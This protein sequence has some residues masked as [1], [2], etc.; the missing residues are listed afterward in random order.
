MTH[1]IEITRNVKLGDPKMNEENEIVEAPQAEVEIE[2]PELSPE[3]LE[4]PIETETTSA[5]QE[6]NDDDEDLPPHL[7]RKIGKIIS[8]ERK[9]L[10]AKFSRQQASPVPHAA[11]EGTIYDP[12]LEDYIDINSTAGQNV[13]YRELVNQ[14][15]AQK[16]A[17]HTQSIK[18]QEYEE[19][20]EK[21]YEG[22]GKFENFQKSLETFAG[23]ATQEMADALCRIEKPDAVIAYLGDKR[24][25]IQR[26][27][28]LKSSQQLREIFRIEDNLT[29]RKKMVTN[30]PAP[31]PK[32][33]ATGGQAVLKRE[34]MSIEQ[35]KAYYEQKFNSR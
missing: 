7:Q 4:E 29:P 10:E 5:P 20:T 31:V 6:I 2:T 33:K 3:N 17:L 25:E 24:G 12:E 35:R 27:S 19:L 13:L 16:A 34:D 30:A 23:L 26:I 1:V 14:K 22:H 8:K 9:R 15:K 11:P 18:Q 21:L 28:R 32:I